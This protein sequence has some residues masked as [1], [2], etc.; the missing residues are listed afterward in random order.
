MAG[1][2]KP[3]NFPIRDVK[4]NQQQNGVIYNPMRYPDHGG[5]TSAAAWPKG[6]PF[7]IEAPTKM[8]TA[9]IAKRDTE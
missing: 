1:L 5:L 3:R 4:S 8:R 7:A 2:V 6:N 9:D